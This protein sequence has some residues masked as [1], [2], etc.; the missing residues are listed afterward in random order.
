MNMKM[1]DKVGCF[2]RDL[3]CGNSFASAPFAIVCPGRPSNP[4]LLYAYQNVGLSKHLEDLG[5]ILVRDEPTI[6]YRPTDA[7]YFRVDFTLLHASVVVRAR[8]SYIQRL[9][10]H[11]NISISPVVSFSSSSERSWRFVSLGPDV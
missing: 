6:F 9:V 10:E 8:K 2:L 5:W 3:P 4:P 11:P 7:P 1:L